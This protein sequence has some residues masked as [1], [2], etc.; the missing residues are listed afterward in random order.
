MKLRS[1]IDALDRSDGDLCI[2]AK[3]PWS[4]D[5]EAELVPLTEDSRVPQPVLDAGY[6]YFLEVGVARDEVLEGL[7]Y[8]T[9]DQRF[10]AILYYA[11]NDTFPNWLIELAR[12]RP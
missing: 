3:R 12:G 2:V 9:P 1:L 8:L 5:A 6:Q 10:E 7:A 4:G 11:E